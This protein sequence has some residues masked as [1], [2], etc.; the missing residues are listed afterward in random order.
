MEREACEMTAIAVLNDRLNH[1]R[2]LGVNLCDGELPIAAQY[3]SDPAL[4][5]ALN[6]RRAEDLCDEDAVMAPPIG[7][8][9]GEGR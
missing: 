7:G 4:D 5:G 9:P 1:H 8:L 3:V 6:K 2:D